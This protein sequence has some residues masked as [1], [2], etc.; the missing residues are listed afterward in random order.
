MHILTITYRSTN[1]YIL[2][3]GKVKLLV[4]AGWPGTLG[5]F[6]HAFSR[7]GIAIKEINYILATHYHPDHAGLVHDIKDEGSKLIVTEEQVAYIPLLKD[8]IKPG[9]DYRDIEMHDNIV[10]SIQGSAVFLNS[11]GFKGQVVYTPGHSDDSITLLL[12]TGEAFI[13]DLP[14]NYFSADSNDAVAIS[15]QNL[16]KLGARKIYP[17]HVRPFAV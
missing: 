16:R 10:I 11:I 17:G 14:P 8:Y 5:E 7:K 15:W 4:D 1:Y 2:D 6:K 9:V 3:N 13:G 12:D